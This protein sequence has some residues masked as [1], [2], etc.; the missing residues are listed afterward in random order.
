LAEKAKKFR[1]TTV[2]RK[3]VT[4][5]RRNILTNNKHFLYIKWATKCTKLRRIAQQG[6]GANYGKLI[7]YELCTKM[8]ILS[9]SAKFSAGQPY[10]QRIICL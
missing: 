9:N 3:H 8:R 1:H 2:N 5:K 7:N 4:S 6:F 10:F